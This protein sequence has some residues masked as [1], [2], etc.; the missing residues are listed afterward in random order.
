MTSS[1]SLATTKAP[2]SIVVA[3]DHPIMREALAQAVRDLPGFSVCCLAESRE[4]LEKALRKHSPDCLV[5]DINMQGVSMLE[6]IP[7]YLRTWPSLKILVVS[8]YDDEL[9][10]Y[11]AFRTGVQGFVSKTA[12]ADE[13]AHALQAVQRGEHYFPPGMKDQVVSRLLSRQAGRGGSWQDKV[14]TLTV[15]ESEV[16]RLLGEWKSTAEIADLLQI[17]PKTVEIHRIHI[18]EKL[19]CTSLPELLRCAV[20]WVGE[21]GPRS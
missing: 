8:A 15:K 13:F 7:D 18:K 5:L 17:S 19:G 14:F 12:M 9:H 21:T 3:D 11:Q 2:V 10:V 6:Q 16:F 1:A 20:S 4:A